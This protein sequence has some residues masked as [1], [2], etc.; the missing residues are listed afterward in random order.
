[1]D[2]IESVKKL[3]L[4]PSSILILR[5]AVSTTDKMLSPV[6]EEIYEWLRDSDLSGVHIF[7]VSGDSFDVNT[8]SN[9]DMNR[10]GWYR[11]DDL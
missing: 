3:D 6:V 11:R 1:M 5:C 7:I 8:I 9:S 10:C 2:V 4:G